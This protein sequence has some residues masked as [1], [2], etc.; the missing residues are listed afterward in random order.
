MVFDLLVEFHKINKSYP[1][2]LVFFR[3][4]VSEGQFPLV[5][6]H[7]MNRLRLACQKVN[8]GYKPAI[9]FIIVQKRHHTRFFPTNPRDQVSLIRIFNYNLEKFLCY[10][11]N[12][13][14]GRAQNVPPGTIVDKTVVSK[15]MFD[16][17]LCSHMG[18]QVN[19]KSL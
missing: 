13:K 12:F 16:Y 1:H 14:S 15:D 3:D 5:L 9:T 4:G 19:F 7:E 17:F 18:I 6:R 2:K 10:H 8:I 11:L